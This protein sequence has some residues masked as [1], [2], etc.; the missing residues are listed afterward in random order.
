MLKWDKDINDHDLKYVPVNTFYAQYIQWYKHYICLIFQTKIQ[1]IN[2]KKHF[3][4]C[5]TNLPLS[6]MI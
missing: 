5:I 2:K 4:F 6:I 3:D 1:T